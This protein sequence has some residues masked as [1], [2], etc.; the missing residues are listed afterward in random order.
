MAT[1]SY[2]EISDYRYR[3]IDYVGG[4]F[5]LSA[6]FGSAYHFA[7]GFRN[8]PSGGRLAGGVRAVRTKVP[9]FA[10]RGGALLAV[11]WAI[12]SGMC[13]A[14]GR[15]EDHWNTIVAG[16]ATCGLAYA[17]R[18]APAATLHALLGAATFAGVVGASLALDLYLYHQSRL[19]SLGREIQVDH[20][21]PPFVQKKNF[22]R[23]WLGTAVA[24]KPYRMDHGAH[25]V[26][27]IEYR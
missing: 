26:G 15:R 13:L 11:I 8:S 25:I 12:E 4:G 18:G 2:G 27:S 9:P 16:T 6:V 23:S 21:S 24:V 17:R 19:N 3:L 7:S 1:P 14:R 10:G 5:S 20:C 22:I